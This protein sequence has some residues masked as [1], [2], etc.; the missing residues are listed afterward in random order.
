MTAA[1]TITNPSRIFLV[2]TNA[3]LENIFL[4]TLKNGLFPARNVRST[5]FQMEVVSL[6]MDSLESGLPL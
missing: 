2:I 1:L 5:P 4:W 6:L 3:K